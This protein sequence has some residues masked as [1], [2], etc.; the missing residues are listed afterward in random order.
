VH[1]E[2]RQKGKMAK[3]QEAAFR[4]M[5]NGYNRIPFSL[6]SFCPFAF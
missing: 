1:V 4:I 2:E 5:G 6:F 3:G